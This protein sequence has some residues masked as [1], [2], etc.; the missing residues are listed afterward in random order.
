MRGGC[1][2]APLAAGTQRGSDAVRTAAELGEE[3]AAGLERSVGG[4]AAVGT[5]A[6]GV[7]PAG[8]TILILFLLHLVET[9]T[10]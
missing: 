8:F 2:A 7:Q 3:A 1:A 6:V 10:F 5:A 9:K 4:Q